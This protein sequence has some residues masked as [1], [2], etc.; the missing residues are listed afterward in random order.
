LSLTSATSVITTFFKRYSIYFTIFNVKDRDGE[1]RE[2][3]NGKIWKRKARTG[4]K[5]K[6]MK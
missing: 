2:K 6:A 5:N 3:I 4:F 1:G